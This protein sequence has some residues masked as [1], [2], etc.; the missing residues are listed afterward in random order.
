M[1]LAAALDADCEIYSDVE[2][3]YSADPRVVPGPRRL[4]EIGYG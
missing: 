4:A 1:A 2:G 3:V